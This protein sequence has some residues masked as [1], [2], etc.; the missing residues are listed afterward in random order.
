VNNNVA[1]NER[2]EYTG[3]DGKLWH[4]NPR[5]TSE[6]IQD[7]EGPWLTCDGCNPVQVVRAGAD[8]HGPFF[9]LGDLR[10][11]YAEAKAAADAAEERR[12]AASDKLKGAL[13]EATNNAY[14][15]S[16]HVDGYRPL[17]LTYVESWR[18]D[19]K[20]L[21]AQHPAVYVEFAKRSGSWRLEESRAK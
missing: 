16:L 8:E 21:Q 5:L 6:D 17:N 15:V 20:A 12:K 14:R 3:A 13:S 10:R 2:G 19:T 7:H 1:T 4:L 11:E 18:L 9:Q